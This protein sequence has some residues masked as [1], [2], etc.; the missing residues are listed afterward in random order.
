[1]LK[2]LSDVYQLSNIDNVPRFLLLLL[3]LGALPETQPHKPANLTKMSIVLGT[4][5]VW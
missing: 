2:L 1:M 4:I 5:P 3:L